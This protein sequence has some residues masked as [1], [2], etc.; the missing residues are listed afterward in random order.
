[1]KDPKFW[2]LLILALAGLVL[3]GLNISLRGAI[4]DKQQQVVARD[5]YI[6]ESE[7]LAQFN[8]N[9]IRAL[10]QLALTTNDEN[11]NRL[12]ADHGISYSLTGGDAD[13]APATTGEGQ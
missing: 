5:Q 2:V 9:F 3:G 1:M 8:N 13:D 10:A 7:Q 6:K 12:L 4:T 11:I